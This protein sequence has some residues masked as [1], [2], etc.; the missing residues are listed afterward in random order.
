MKNRNAI[1]IYEM[2]IIQHKCGHKMMIDELI[3]NN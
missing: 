2:S 1:E 3:H